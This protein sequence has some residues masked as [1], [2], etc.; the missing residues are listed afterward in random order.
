MTR[1]DVPLCSAPL[2][3]FLLLGEMVFKVFHAFGRQWWGEKRE[4]EREKG[5]GREERRGESGER[6]D[7]KFSF[8]YSNLG[9]PSKVIRIV[10][11]RSKCL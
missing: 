10:H 3:L 4:R 1:E 9:W 11:Y 2:S 6:A 7:A 5:V 8:S